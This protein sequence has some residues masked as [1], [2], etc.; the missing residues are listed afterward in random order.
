MCGFLVKTPPLL[1]YDHDEGENLVINEYEAKTVRLIF[2]MYLYG[3]TCRQIADTLTSLGRKPKKQ[4]TGWS[5]G[6]VLQILQNERHCGDVLERKIWTPSYLDHKSR[7]NKKNRNQYRKNDHHEAIIS[8]GAFIAAQHLISNTKYGNKGILPELQ[9]ITEDALQ[10]F[11]S[12]NPR[13]AGFTAD[14]YIRAS[15]SVCDTDVAPLADCIEVEAQTGIL[16]CADMK[17]QDRNF[18]IPPQNPA[19]PFPSMN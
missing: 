12:I 10:G 17:S 16:I 7:K 14:D 11:V 9:V 15:R 4:N 2:F 18:L 13:W 1:G 6:S 5:P 3:Y 19:S 8:R